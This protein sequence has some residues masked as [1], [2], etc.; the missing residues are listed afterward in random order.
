VK[1]EYQEEIDAVNKK[2]FDMR[3]AQLMNVKKVL[4][5]QSRA[6]MDAVMLRCLDAL[7]AEEQEKIK[8]QET[9]KQGEELMAKI[10][11]FSATAAGNAQKVMSRMSAGN[12]TGL[13]P[14]AWQGWRQYMEEFKNDTELSKS[15]REKERQV[16]AFKRK[17]KEGAKGVLTSMTN[18]SN[19]ALQHSVYMAWID[20][21]KERKEKERVESALNAKS[22]Q[23]SNFQ[24][25]NKAAGMSASEKT[26]FLQDAQLL[27]FCM[28]QWKKDARVERI[29]RLGKEKD[30]KRKKEL[31]GV[32]G[33]FKSFAS[34]LETSLTSGTPRV[35]VKPKRQS[36]TSASPA[37]DEGLAVDD[38]SPEQQAPSPEGE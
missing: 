9:A 33:M 11:S 38:G 36:P 22:A 34:E 4:N 26:A 32:K 21:I 25:K 5:K 37:A 3:E 15:L 8:A 29:R 7:K 27:I 20:L 35:D 14:L 18:A 6:A 28:C 2:L 23:M 1:A 12:E 19:S 30:A 13:K 31:V 10:Q 24:S 17:Q 16:E